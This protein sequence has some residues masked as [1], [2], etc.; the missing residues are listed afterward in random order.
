MSFQG[1]QANWGASTNSASKSSRPLSLVALTILR[2]GSCAPGAL[3]GNTRGLRFVI[4][5]LDAGAS[6]R[7]PMRFTFHLLFA[8]GDPNPLWPTT[9]PFAREAF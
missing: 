6:A 2:I 3:L 4:H 7:S 1:R 9:D 5:R 8:V